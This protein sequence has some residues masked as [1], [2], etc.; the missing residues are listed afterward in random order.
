MGFV[1]ECNKNNRNDTKLEKFGGSAKP[2][3]TDPTLQTLRYR[4]YTTDPTL[5]KVN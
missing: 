1:P 3:A 5:Q 2:Y 4:P